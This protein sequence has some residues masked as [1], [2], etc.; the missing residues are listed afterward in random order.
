MKFLSKYHKGEKLAQELANER[1][2]ADFNGQAISNEIIEGA[3]SF[4]SEQE[5]VVTGI[6]D[7]DANV[8]VSVLSG[9]RGFMEAPDPKS[10]VIHRTK[11]DSSGYNP[12]LEHL[13]NGN[14]VGLLII[15][16]ASRRRLRVNGK[17]SKFNDDR[18][19]IKVEQA[20]PNC[21][22]Y[23]QRRHILNRES[24]PHSNKNMEVGYLLTEAQKNIISSADTFFIGSVHPNG[25]LDASHRGGNPGFAQL[26]DDK[27]IRIPDYK[28]NSMFNTFGN[29]LLNN[30]AG[31]VFWN[32]EDGKLLHLIGTAHIVW[33]DRDNTISD[34]GRYWEF[35]IQKWR[36]DVVGRNFSWE[37]L[38]YSPHNPTPI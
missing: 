38:D 6:T 33:D 17:I 21:M 10:I 26:V 31:I 16:L 28:G 12:V 2:Q 27:A 4:I 30:N 20:Y 7:D 34:T 5:Y 29:L 25:N 18:I 32:F 22:K 3:L 36:Q 8:W 37:F 11:L 35:N 9:D 14:K 19:E 13:K 24:W 15:E 23:I 1:R